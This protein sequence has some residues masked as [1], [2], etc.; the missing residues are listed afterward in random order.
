MAGG[1]YTLALSFVLH[2]PLEVPRMLKSGSPLSGN[3]PLLG[4]SVNRGN[5]PPYTT[6]VRRKLFGRAL[7]EFPCRYGL[8][9]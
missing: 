5:P 6:V 2:L 7:L 9:E 3:T 8:V 1:I 4:F